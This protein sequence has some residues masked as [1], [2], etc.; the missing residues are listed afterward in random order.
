MPRSENSWP[1]ELADLPYAAALTP[2]DSGTLEPGYDYDTVHFDKDDFEEPDASG[3]RFLECAFTGVSFTKGGLRRS[4]FI[5]AWLKDARITLTDLAETQWVDTT[6]AGGVVA[7]V[8]A[9][10][11][12]LNRVVFAGC[13][14]DSVN[15][16]EAQLTEVTFT[17][18]LV[19]DVDFSGAKLTRTVFAGCKLSGA[20]FSRAS[21]DRL[22]L[23]GSE[24]G[25]IV[26]PD[27]LRGAIISSGQLATIAPVLAEALG[28]IVNDE[29]PGSRG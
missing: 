11:A 16:R 7:G 27:P 13:K 3:A 24:L 4:R 29:C 10:G 6:F 18:C 8:Q 1:R 2:P 25:L 17:D 22:D 5:E 21:L 9:F 15:F 20:D 14:L 26:G 23:R 19:R 12:R 28:I